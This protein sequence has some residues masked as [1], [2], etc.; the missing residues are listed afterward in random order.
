MIPAG[1]FASSLLASW[2]L[3]ATAALAL[4]GWLVGGVERPSPIVLEIV[5]PPEAGPGPAASPHPPS[6]SRR[7]AAPRPD[8]RSLSPTTGA[9]VPEPTQVGRAIE[10]PPSGGNVISSR[11]TPPPGPSAATGGTEGRSFT[12]PHVGHRIIPRYP[13]SARRA[14]VQGTAVLRVRVLADGTVGELLIE[15]SSGNSDLDAAAVEAVRRW[16]F[17]AARRGGAPVAVWVL[18]PF[19]FTLG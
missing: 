19:R 12:G 14:G 4:W 16:R 15:Q 3:H 7:V 10:L 2:A 8:T 9:S 13:E 6:P 5:G 1:R 17:E 11:E 18:I